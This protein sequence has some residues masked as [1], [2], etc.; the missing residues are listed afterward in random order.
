MRSGKRYMANPI[1]KYRAAHRRIRRI[2]TLYTTKLC[3]VCNAPCCLKPTQVTEFDVLIA[4]S[5]GQNL[6]SVDQDTAIKA[7]MQALWGEEM[8]QGLEP[9]DYLGE[10]GCIF[11]DDLRPFGC[12]RWLCPELKAAIPPKEMRELRDLMHK[13]GTIHRELMDSIVPKR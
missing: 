13:L 9:C 12:T 2:L 1:E 3:P 5:C 8:D 7:T 4:N 11:P 6:P 10:N